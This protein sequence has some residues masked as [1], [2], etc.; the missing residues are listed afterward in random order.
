VVVEDFSWSMNTTMGH[1]IN[2]FCQAMAEG[3]VLGKLGRFDLD[4]RAIKNR[5]VRDPQTE[6]LKPNATA[7]ALLSLRKGKWEEGDPFNRLFEITFDRYSGRDIHAKQEE[8]LS[9]LFGWKDSVTEVRHNDELL[10]ASRDAKAQ[11][12]ALKKAFTAG[13]QPGEFIQVKVPFETPDGGQEWMWVEI[14]AWRGN[15]I[16]GLLKNEPFNIPSLHGGQI[17][18]VKQEDAF[19]YIRHYPDGRQEGNETATIIQKMQ[20]RKD[21]Q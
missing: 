2:L 16:S 12:P 21:K 7:V 11:L 18:E 19:D 14:T 3:A 15:K 4:L 8:M 5:K 17:V 9:S 20:E 13:L 6:S 10:A 1:L